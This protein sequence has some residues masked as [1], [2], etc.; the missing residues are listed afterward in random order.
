MR[1]KKSTDAISNILENAKNFFS[2][3]NPEDYDKNDINKHMNLTNFLEKETN[4]KIDNN[5]TTTSLPTS[6]LNISFIL[7]TST[8]PTP[9]D[10]STKTIDD[11]KN[12]IPFEKVTSSV[13]NKI[14]M[15]PRA[16]AI[17]QKVLQQLEKNTPKPISYNFN[18]VHNYPETIINN[19]IRFQKNLEEATII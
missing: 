9:L 7:K 10:I 2:D 3:E 12:T 15:P 1:V 16:Y 11:I 4:I 13:I 14:V 5:I 17:Y 18:Q 6:P 19:T 8:T